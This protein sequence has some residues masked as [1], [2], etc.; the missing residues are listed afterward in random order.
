M[1]FLPCLFESGV[2]LVC[3]ICWL[4]TAVQRETSGSESQLHFLQNLYI[5]AFSIVFS[6]PTVSL[7]VLPCQF[8]HPCCSKPRPII[9][10]APV[11]YNGWRCLVSSG[12]CSCIPDKVTDNSHSLLYTMKLKYML[13]LNNIWYGEVICLSLAS[14]SQIGSAN[15]NI[16]TVYTTVSHRGKYLWVEGWSGQPALVSLYLYTSVFIWMGRRSLCS[17]GLMVLS[18]PPLHSMR[19]CFGPGPRTKPEARYSTPASLDSRW[20][21]ISWG[22]IVHYVC[23]CWRVDAPFNCCSLRVKRTKVARRSSLLLLLSI[24]EVTSVEVDTGCHGEKTVSH[25]CAYHS[26]NGGPGGIGQSAHLELGTS[27][28]EEVV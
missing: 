27:D 26:W 15:L 17:R 13:K 3:D 9:F 4:I 8:H 11:E 18:C 10:S 16:F 20:H 22:D 21:Y 19:Q 24:C 23:L 2:R 14:K 5:K 7:L 1:F 12:N 25:G 6:P 28:L